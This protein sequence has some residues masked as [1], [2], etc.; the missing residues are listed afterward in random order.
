MKIIR[1]N[2]SNISVGT[3]ASFKNASIVAVDIDLDNLPEWLIKLFYSCPG[4]LINSPVIYTTTTKKRFLR[5]AIANGFVGSVEDLFNAIQNQLSLSIVAVH[6][7][8]HEI[9]D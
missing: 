7:A 9:D 5:D 8:R 4:V 1:L 3:R 6:Q 2:L